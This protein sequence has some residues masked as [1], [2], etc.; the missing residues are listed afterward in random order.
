MVYNER[1]YLSHCI[2]L[3]ITV[4]ETVLCGSR[5]HTRLFF[6][7]FQNPLLLSVFSLVGSYF[8]MNNE[9]NSFTNTYS[10]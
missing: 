3:S 6:F 2:I 5:P 10:L 4:E 8:P 9:I 7:F 1:I